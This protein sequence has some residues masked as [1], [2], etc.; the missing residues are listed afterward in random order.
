MK[1]D[2]KDDELKP[3][4]DLING[5]SEILKAIAGNVKEWAGNWD[6]LWDNIML[7]A[8][9]KE[10]IANSAEEHNDP[11]L[12]EAEFVIE[13]NDQFH[14]ISEKI[15]EKEGILNS[16]KIFFEWNE[17]MKKAIKKRKLNSGE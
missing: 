8:K 5:D 16:K 14:N 3:T 17:W 10:T 15:R 1:Y 11:E 6:A 13:A 7:R 4:T 12:L 2:S 9:I